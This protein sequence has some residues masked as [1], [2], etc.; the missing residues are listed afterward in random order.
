[1]YKKPPGGKIKTTI[2]FIIF[3][4]RHKIIY[5]F[6]SHLCFYICENLKLHIIEIY[7]D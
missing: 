5:N 2:S 4:S 6:S 7:G 1:M 3:Q